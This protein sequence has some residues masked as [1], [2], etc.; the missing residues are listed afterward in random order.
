MGCLIY[1]TIIDTRQSRQFCLNGGIIVEKSRRKVQRS[2]RTR[3]HSQQIQNEQ[4][5]MIRVG[6]QL[7]VSMLIFL[8]IMSIHFIRTE[9]SIQIIQVVKTTLSYDMTWKEIISTVKETASQIPSMKTWGLFSEDEEQEKQVEPAKEEMENK[10]IDE[11][12]SETVDNN[13]EFIL[14]PNLGEKQ[15]NIGP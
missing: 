15:E 12:S 5:R 13:I 4:Q 10:T 7:L 14:E 3:Y 2:I 8:L 6:R 11:K 9:Q 1:C